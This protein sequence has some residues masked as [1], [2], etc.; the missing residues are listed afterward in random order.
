MSKFLSLVI[1][2]LLLSF[3]IILAQDIVWVRPQEIDSVLVNPGIALPTKDVF[4]AFDKASSAREQTPSPSKPG[5][6]LLAFIKAQSNDLEP[7]AI[8]LQPVIGQVLAALTAA[9]G[10][11]LARMS[12]SGATCF[13]LFDTLEA[14]SA[15]AEKLRAAHSDW[16]IEETPLG[17]G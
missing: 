15:S 4:G 6:D 13:G 11:R 8:A 14:A 17:A 10:C 16:W 12:G 5:E 1:L 3:S 9:K 2:F 7:V